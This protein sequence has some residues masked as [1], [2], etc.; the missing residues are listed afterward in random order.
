M[1]HRYWVPAL[2][3]GIILSGCLGWRPDVPEVDRAFYST[4]KK[5]G[6]EKKSE[7]PFA[8]FKK[9]PWLGKPGDD[10]LEGD[11]TAP[12][13]D[14]QVQAENLASGGGGVSAGAASQADP[15]EGKKNRSRELNKSAFDALQV[16][17][18]AQAEKHLKE[19]LELDPKNLAALTNMGV[20]YEKTQ[21]PEMARK[22][23][24][25]AILANPQ[26]LLKA[27]DPSVRSGKNKKVLDLILG[28]WNN[29]NQEKDEAMALK[30]DVVNGQKVYLQFCSEKCHQPNGWGDKEG[31]YPQIAGQ[32]KDVTIKQ[33][34][35]I[36]SKN[37]DN[38]EMYRFSLASEVG[39]VQNIADVSAF[40]ESMPMTD[41]NGK[42]PGANLER[43]KKLYE[44][45]C[46]AC[47]GKDGAGDGT[48]LFELVYGQHYNYL[49]RQFQ[50]IKE[51]KRRNG[52]PLMIIQVE[53]YTPDDITA[54]MD[55]IS[56][57]KVP[58]S[59]KQPLKLEQSP[60]KTPGKDAEK[61]S[62]L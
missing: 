13:G 43:G 28:E 4:Q 61:D 8:S 10:T 54:V 53:A 7:P 30:G 34:A 39:G 16:K 51:E 1:M 46:A 35:D 38:P 36:R 15:E 59:K 62:L 6:T 55:Y 9:A 50:W 41:K 22:M 57:M 31:K 27:S 45:D 48:K 11:E 23:Y 5:E 49:L 33:L 2:V 47:H 14:D 12:P 3:L 37:R 52:H 26:A 44:S 60:A 29:R 42:G 19:A 32:Y 18:Y 56:R 58:S 20:V 24:R 40:I 25:K 17:D 21:K